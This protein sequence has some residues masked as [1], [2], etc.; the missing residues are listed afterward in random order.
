MNIIFD[1]DGT[2]ID[3]SERMYQLFQMLVPQSSFTKSEYLK[4]K[5][6]KVSHKM[7]LEKYFSGISFDSFSVKWKQEIEKEKYILLDHNY[8]DTIEVLNELSKKYNLFL[9][10]ARQ[11]ENELI[12]ELQRLKLKT[13]FAEI[14][15]SKGKCSKKELLCDYE[16]YCSGF[17]NNVKYYVTDMGEDILIGNELGLTTI[18]I[19]HGFM[20]EVKLMEYDPKYIINTLTELV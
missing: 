4:L 5:R 18:A 9:L 12:K 20:S 3:S 19:T 8:A 13:F 15:I 14:F 11:S 1:L 6:D 10:T 17:L 16:N 7:I 2:L